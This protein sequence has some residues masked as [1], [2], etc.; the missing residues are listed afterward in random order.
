MKFDFYKTVIVLLLAAL[1]FYMFKL[2]KTIELNAKENAK[3]GRFVPIGNLVLDT[4][5]GATYNEGK[6]YS[7]PII[8]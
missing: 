5:T 1:T 7:D 6:V 3:A 2:S 8:K 4:Q